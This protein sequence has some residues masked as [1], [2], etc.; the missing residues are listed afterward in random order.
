[1]MTRTTYFLRDLFDVY[2]THRYMGE[3]DGDIVV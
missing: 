3:S 2:N 1:M